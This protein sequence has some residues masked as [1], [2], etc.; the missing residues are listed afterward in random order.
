MCQLTASSLLDKWGGWFFLKKIWRYNHQDSAYFPIDT[1]L[2]SS[3][4]SSTVLTTV[5]IP[6]TWSLFQLPE[7]C[8]KVRHYGILQRMSPS[9]PFLTGVLMLDLNK[10]EPKGATDFFSFLRLEHNIPSSHFHS[11]VSVIY[12]LSWW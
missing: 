11:H 9:L 3:S 1:S 2:S 5:I 8:E 4:P 7:Q 6:T 10:A 12:P